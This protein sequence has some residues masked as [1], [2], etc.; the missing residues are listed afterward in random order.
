MKAN[1][2]PRPPAFDRYKSFDHDD[3]TVKHCY[4]GSS[5]PLDVDGIKILIKM[6]R[7]QNIKIEITMFCSS[8]VIFINDIVIVG[9]NI[10]KW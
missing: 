5:M 1:E 3:H 7:P 10:A 9:P 8:L 4:L 2:Q 6:T